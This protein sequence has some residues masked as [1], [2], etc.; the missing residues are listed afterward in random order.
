MPACAGM[1]TVII[2]SILP[3]HVHSQ[4]LAPIY[5]PLTPSPHLS[6]KDDELAVLHDLNDS[7]VIGIAV[8]GEGELA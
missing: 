5:R 3:I 1:T 6:R 2:L 8:F 4:S 7:R